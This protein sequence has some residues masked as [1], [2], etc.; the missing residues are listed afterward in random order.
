MTPAHDLGSNTTCWEFL[1]IR[2]GQYVQEQ[3]AQGITPTDDM[4]Q[5]QARIILYDDDDSWD[6]TCADHPEWLTLF[7]KAHNIVPV[8]PG[9]D[10]VDALEDLG[11]QLSTISHLHAEAQTGPSIAQWMDWSKGLTG[12]PVSFNG[13]YTNL[14][15][16]YTSV[17]HEDA[18]GNP[19]VMNQ[20]ILGLRYDLLP[21]A[22]VAQRMGGE[23]SMGMC[24]NGLLPM[25]SSGGT[26]SGPSH[27]TTRPATNASPTDV[28]N[29]GGEHEAFQFDEDMFADINFDQTLAM[30]GLDFSSGLPVTG[31]GA[32][33]G[34]PGSGFA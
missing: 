8:E 34:M 31:D 25:S 2:L 27:N 9:F 1:T 14:G 28:M 19:N 6:T 29:T 5:R 18:V 15:E 22:G 23:S 32:G 30:D 4:L 24:T 11:L 20:N 7:K 21:T 16:F 33:T 10:R 26:L 13:G 12:Q 17:G 3:K